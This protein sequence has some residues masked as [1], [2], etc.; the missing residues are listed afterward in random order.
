VTT[1]TVRRLVLIRHAKAVQ[2]GIDAERP[3]AERG[4]VDAPAVGRWLAEHD[5]Q[6]D[7]VVVS[8][9]RRASQTWQLAAAELGASAEPVVDERV[10]DNTVGALLQIVRESPA[11]VRTL[12]LVGHNPSI[13]ELASVLDD[14]HGEP[15]AR[16]ELARKYPTSGIAVIELG[17]EW[18]LV[19]F[20]SGKLRQFAAPRG[21]A[22]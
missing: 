5:L 4:L 21:G 22:G 20:G 9:A 13:A 7:R 15:D 16:H 6:P 10:Y 12:A 19:D 14:R 3:L 18:E 1:P 17:I 2:G 8:P 11:D